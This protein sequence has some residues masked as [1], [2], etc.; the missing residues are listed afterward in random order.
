MS[1]L[2]KADLKRSLRDKLFLVLCII[3][4]AF[5]LV[6]PLLYK[7]IFMLLQID[8][9]AMQ[10]LEMLGIGINAKS[11]FFG[12]FSLGNNFGFI[13]PIFI[14][15]ILC[16]DFSHG[17]IRNKIICGKS[18]TSIYFSMLITCTALICVLIM[19]H[20]V[21]TLLISLL[22]FDYQATPFTL[23]DFGYL[24]ASVALELLVYL[25]LCALLTFFIV[26]MKNAGLAIVMY[27]VVSF[28]MMIAGGITQ[29]VV[30]FADPASTSYGILEFFNTANIFVT[31]A[32]GNGTSYELQDVL[33]LVLPV[34]ASTALFI[35]LG[36]LSFKKK[37]IK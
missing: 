25:F 18:R 29:T 4:A 19:A 13:L 37:D 31:T 7:G 32:I 10:E 14:V 24:M 11:M 22:F 12:S 8:A 16:K 17:T 20:A 27:F 35:A 23:G 9:N 2:L 34:V 36:F 15:I 3:A 1:D 26:R 6:T 30:I 5:A 28:T 33:Y 21:L